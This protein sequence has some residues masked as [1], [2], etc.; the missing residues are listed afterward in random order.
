MIFSF[1]SKAGQ[2]FCSERRLKFNA[3][4][5]YG[6]IYGFNIQPFSQLII[7]ILNYFS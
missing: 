3:V 1:P 2:E 4:T 6:G 5:K 7:R